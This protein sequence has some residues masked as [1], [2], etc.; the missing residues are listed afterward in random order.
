M[1]KYI[2][3]H[4]IHVF[5]EYERQYISKIE[6]AFS[7]NKDCMSRA[8]RRAWKRKISKSNLKSSVS[9][10]NKMNKEKAIELIKEVKDSL[11]LTK[12]LYMGKDEHL[13]AY[14]VLNMQRCEQAI[15]E[16]ED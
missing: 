1:D 12:G 4:L 15:K 6:E 8:E 10:P 11:F 5:E 14:M 2:P 3:S 7:I 13:T 16:L 9:K